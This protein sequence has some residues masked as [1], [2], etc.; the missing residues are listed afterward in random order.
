MSYNIL[1]LVLLLIWQ[2]YAQCQSIEKIFKEFNL[3]YL[4][5]SKNSCCG[6]PS[7]YIKCEF[8]TQ[9]ITEL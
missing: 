3:E 5:N 6:V 9:R 2:C 1:L 7:K 4:F 8:N